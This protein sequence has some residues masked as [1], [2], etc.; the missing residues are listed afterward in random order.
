MTGTDR[1]KKTP[2]PVKL[3]LWAHLKQPQVTQAF[4][5]ALG[6]DATT[7]AY[8]ADAL[9]RSLAEGHPCAVIWHDPVVPMAGALAAGTP[10]G[11]VLEM[12]R[13]QALGLLDLIRRNRRRLVSLSEPALTSADPRTRAQLQDRLGLS[14]DFRVPADAVKEDGDLFEIL[15]KLTVPVLDHMRPLL[16]E[17]EASSIYCPRATF[18]MGEL[19]QAVHRLARDQ[20][21]ATDEAGLLRDQ[22]RFMQQGLDDAGAQSAREKGKLEAEVAELRTSLQKANKDVSKAADAKARVEAELGAMHEALIARE[23]ELAG[24]RGATDE[25]FASNSWKVTAPLRRFSLL[26]GRHRS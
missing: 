17:L 9:A 3:F 11:P 5:E 10:L 13:A 16:S 12:W 2:L 25:I 26:M 14:D 21:R 19:E 15:S 24:L 23:N 7:H 8:D 20:S 18:E 1:T 4:A 22:I 6:Q